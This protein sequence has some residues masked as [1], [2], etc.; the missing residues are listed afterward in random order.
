M[1]YGQ[2]YRSFSFR[3]C[4]GPCRLPCAQ[5][6]QLREVSESVAAEEAHIFKPDTAFRTRMGHVNP[7]R[8]PIGENP[9]SGAILYYYLKEEPKEPAKLEIL[10]SQG[11]VIRSYTSEEKKKQEAAEEWERDAPEEHIP[12]KAGLNRFTCDLRYEVPGKIP[13]TVYAAREPLAPL[14]LPGAYQGRLTLAGKSQVAPFV[15]KIDPRVPTSADDL[16]K[17]FELILKMRGRLD[18]MNKIILAIRET[19]AQLQSIEKRLGSGKAEKSLVTPSA[20]CRRK[21]TAIEEELIQ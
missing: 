11:K 9:P 2:P 19:R 4:R 8:Y 3:S 14:V 6:G 7:R 16:R 15:V 13:L 21:I 17:Q 12:A 20:D 10:D 5:T 1:G 18:D